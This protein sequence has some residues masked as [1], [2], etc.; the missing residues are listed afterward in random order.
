MSDKAEYT[1]LASVFYQ[2]QQGGARK[3]FRAGDIITGLSV[4][5]ADRLLKIGAIAP[6][7]SPAPAAP[8]PP[9]PA[10]DEPD[11]DH[12][13]NDDDAV[14]EVA[15]PARPKAAQ[16][17][18]VWRAYATAVGIPEEQ[19]ADMTKKQLQEATR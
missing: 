10:A 1:L 7:G 4:D 8:P 9:A 19:A 13:D 6:I 17:V 12:S 15:A 2:R 16:S 3:R 11:T 18:E 14:V 5:K